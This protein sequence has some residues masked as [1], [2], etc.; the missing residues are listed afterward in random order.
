VRRGLEL[1]AARHAY[2]E[3]RRLRGQVRL[4]I[5]VESLRQ[6]HG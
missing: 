6:D 2:E 3:L 5:D 1:V 4:S